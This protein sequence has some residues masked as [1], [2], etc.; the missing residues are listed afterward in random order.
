MF[1]HFEEAVDTNIQEVLIATTILVKV[2]G[3]GTIEI[4]FIF[5][6]KVTLLNVLFLLEM[7]KNLF[8][9]DFFVQRGFKFCLN[10]TRPSC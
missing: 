2:V 7:R 4:D 3:K 10:L 9:I 8:S 1:K 5:R 6:K